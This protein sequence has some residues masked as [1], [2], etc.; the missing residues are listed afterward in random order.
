MTTIG[1]LDSTVKVL[2]AL[3]RLAGLTTS[4]GSLTLQGEAADEVMY[5]LLTRGCRVAQRW[6]LDC[7]YVGW[8]S[9]NTTI[10]W[11]GDDATGQGRYTSLPTQFLR[12]YSPRDEWGRR[13]CLTEPNGER[14]GIEIAPED[15]HRKGNFYYFFDT[16]GTEQLWL[17]RDANP[18]ATI[19][20][21]YHKY[22]DAWNSGTT[23]NFPLTVRHL[24]VS[25]A[26]SLGMDESYFAGGQEQ[27]AAIS[28][29]LERDREH[30][31]DFAR[32]SK[33]PRQIR[34]PA[35]FGNF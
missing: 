17:A 27:R 32:Q 28:Q 20:M 6:L 25:E 23:I 18:P 31:Q 29:Q 22:H 2:A 1:E 12:A 14:W 10:T 35:R 8:R 30:A 7:G 19:Y 13:T 24:I 3:Y 16:D 9:Q 21:N 11:S 4:D 26:A 33:R 34:R 5:Q 15:R